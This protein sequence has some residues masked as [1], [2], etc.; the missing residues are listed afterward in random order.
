M[1]C[2]P[3]ASE[4]F[5]LIRSSSF[6]RFVSS[7]V[8]TPRCRRSRDDLIAVSAPEVRNEVGVRRRAAR[9]RAARGRR[10]RACARATWP[11]CAESSRPAPTLGAAEGL[12]AGFARRGARRRR[13]SRDDEQ[14]GCRELA[15]RAARWVGAVHGRASVR[16]R[17]HRITSQATRRGRSRRVREGRPY[18][19]PTARPQVTQNFHSCSSSLPQ[20][21]QWRI[22]R[23]CPQ[24][25][26]KLI[27]RPAGSSPLQ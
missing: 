1:N 18:P 17:V 4:G 19:A 25:G 8:V 20:A 3:V 5:T 11:A 9:R 6:G 24:C 13:A 10:A 7:S 14:R 2:G 27:G 22:V 21:G 12:V 26:Q 15:L 23:S 16:V